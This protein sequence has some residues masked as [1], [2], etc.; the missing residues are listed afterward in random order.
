MPVEY[1]RGGAR[2][3]AFFTELAN[4]ADAAGSIR[5]DLYPSTPGTMKQSYFFPTVASKQIFD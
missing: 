5:H 2:H 3:S 4:D 1:V